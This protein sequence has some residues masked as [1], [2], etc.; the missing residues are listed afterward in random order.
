MTK[1]SNA[2]FCRPQDIYDIANV[3][4]QDIKDKNRSRISRLIKNE[5][6][7]LWGDDYEKKIARKR[8]QAAGRVALRV[9]LKSSLISDPLVFESIQYLLD[10]DKCFIGTYRQQI[11]SFIQNNFSKTMGTA[12]GVF[13][14][15]KGEFEHYDEVKDLLSTIHKNGGLVK[16]IKGRDANT[17]HVVHDLKTRGIP[18][19][20]RE[21]D[22]PKIRLYICDEK[23]LF[24]FPVRKK[25]FIGFTG[26]CSKTLE[27]LKEL[28]DRE[29]DN[30]QQ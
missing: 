25:K 26:N 22:Y 21:I 9:A 6:R 30:A 1:S 24:C 17:F 15:L 27:V 29:W 19:R 10:V 16:I 12:I 14:T 2:L 18:V 8:S 5:Y 3:T 7:F 13:Y 23:Y 11:G 4:D 28:F 20:I